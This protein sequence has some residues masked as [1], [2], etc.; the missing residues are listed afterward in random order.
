MLSKKTDTVTSVASATV[1]RKSMA[2]AQIGISQPVHTTF[3]AAL[4]LPDLSHH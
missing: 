2:V 4:E 1:K 3:R